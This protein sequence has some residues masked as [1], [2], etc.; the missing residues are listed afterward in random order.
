METRNKK[1]ITSFSTNHKTSPRSINTSLDKPV[2]QQ[3]K[4]DFNTLESPERL[5]NPCKQHE[6]LILK[7]FDSFLAKQ[8]LTNGKTNVNRRQKAI[9]RMREQ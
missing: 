4:F 6:G 9:M 3:T 5:A 1:L 7:D 8:Q 2:L